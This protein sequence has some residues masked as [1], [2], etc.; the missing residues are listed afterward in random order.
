MGAIKEVVGIA[1]GE[2]GSLF[3]SGLNVLADTATSI[4]GSIKAIFTSVFDNVKSVATSAINRVIEKINNMIATINNVGGAI[5]VNIKSITP[6]GGGSA[7]RRG[8]GGPVIAGKP[9]IVG[10]N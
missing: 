4:G 5:G 9:Y 7:E 6:I 8:V 10:E 2:L 3:D 1:L